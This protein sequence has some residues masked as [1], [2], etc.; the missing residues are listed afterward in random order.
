MRSAASTLHKLWENVSW[1]PLLLLFTCVSPL[2]RT[3][4]VV[5]V[6]VAI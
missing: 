5:V 6:C 2:S 4:G 1:I 3:L